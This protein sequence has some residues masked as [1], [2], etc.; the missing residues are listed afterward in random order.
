MRLAARGVTVWSPAG[1]PTARAEDLAVRLPDLAGGSRRVVDVRV[2]GLEADLERDARGRF[3]LLDLLPPETD[4]PSDQPLAIQI[5]G[6]RLR[7]FDRTAADVR[8]RIIAIP[9]LTFDGDGASWRASGRLRDVDGGATE[10]KARQDAKTQT[11]SLRAQ[12]AGL[13]LAPW[14]PIVRRTPAAKNFEILRE[15][16]AESFRARGQAE[17]T[18]EAQRPVALRGSLTA[19]AKGLRYAEF[20]ARSAHLIGQFDEASADGMLEAERPGLRARFSG[21]VNW[22]E[23]VRAFGRLEANAESSAA[24]PAALQKSLPKALAFRSAH[25]DGGMAF[26]PSTGFEVQ[27]AL[28]AQSATWDRQRFD[29]LSARVYAGPEWLSFRLAEGHSRGIRFGGAGDVALKARTLALAGHSDLIPIERFRAELGTD[30][31][32]GAAELTATVTG[33]IDRPE[34]ELRAKGVA[35]A[36]LQTGQ[37]IELGPFMGVAHLNGSRLE[38]KRLD[39][40]GPVG[41]ASVSG[42]YHFETQALDLGVVANGIDLASLRPDLAGTATGRFAVS[43]T[44]RDVRAVGPV[45]I[46]GLS[47]QEQTI[48]LVGAELEVGSKSLVA[49]SVTAHRGSARAQGS[50]RWTYDTGALDGSFSAQSLQLH[51][52]FAEGIEGGV[53]VHGGQIGGTLERPRLE[54]RFQGKGLL[55]QGVKV[56][57]V[58]GQGQIE[59]KRLAMVGGEAT[60]GR[61]RLQVSGEYDLDTRVGKAEGIAKGLPFEAV[62]ALLP[63]EVVLAGGVDFQFSAGLAEGQLAEAKIEGA[64]DRLGING[65]LFGSGEFL[66]SNQ[67][68]RWAGRVEIGQPER[69]IEIDSFQYDRDTDRL[70]AKLASY[71]LPLRDLF[72]AARPFATGGPDAPE[73]GDLLSPS[74]LAMLDRLDGDLDVGLALSGPIGSPNLAIDSILLRN[75]VVD[76]ESAGQIEANGSRTDKQW[77]IAGMKWTGGPGTL[78]LK[79]GFT[80][81]GPISIDGNLYNLDTKWLSR[82]LPA[83]QKVSGEATLFFSVSGQTQN[84]QIEASLS[85]SLFEAALAGGPRNRDQELKLDIYPILVADGAISVNGLFNFRGFS[86]DLKGSIPFRYPFEFPADQEVD[87]ALHVPKRPIETLKDLFTKLDVKRTKGAVWADVAV[88]GKPN[89]LHFDGTVNLEAES[90]GLSEFDTVLTNVQAQSRFQE[91]KV[92]LSATAKSS[93]GGDVSAQGAVQFQSFGELFGGNLDEMLANRIEGSLRFNRLKVEERDLPLDPKRTSLL[94]FSVGAVNGGVRVSGSLRDPLISTFVPLALENVRGEI[95]SLLIE[96]AEA[97]PPLVS[98]RFNIAYVVGTRQAPAEVRAAASVLNLYGGGTLKG[99][100]EDLE[101]QANLTLRSGYLRL[102]NARINLQD[103]GSVKLRYDSGAL[104]SDLRLDVDIEGRTALSAIRFGSL[105]E[106]YDIYLEM[107]GNLLNPE[108]QIISARSDPPDLSQERIMNLLGQIELVQ[109]LSSQLTGAQER[110]QLEQAL[111]TLA[112]PVLFDPVTESLARQLGLEYL[113]L[114]Y[115]PLGQ[116]SAIAAKWLGKGFTLQGRREI[117]EAA[118]GISDYDLRLTYRPPRRIRSLRGLTFSVGIDQERP[119]KIAVEYG[120]RFG[121][122]GGSANPRIIKIG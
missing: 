27:G 106:R 74:A 88:N 110:R 47:I 61:G 82:F 96:S 7:F 38:V 32:R 57:A 97:S 42:T 67:G 41:V 39:I 22:S 13:D 30:R 23:A 36:A 15:L 25:F 66:V 55:L 104:D 85:G 122:S 117:S 19:D 113:S 93:K 86:G 91:G 71:S 107:R 65:A 43:G 51:D 5:E 37:F 8:P 44:P 11:L 4:E 80:E 90:I 78:D 99:R 58:Q 3:T 16:D 14:L 56:D 83:L 119:W 53:E 46:Y 121:S 2:R 95:P 49:R 62:H 103:G 118:D 12:L 94:N 116:T 31:L 79:G 1:E 50:V 26:A 48:P 87:I 105:I 89:A 6:A 68:P 24:L 98:P 33:S 52:F 73:A 17:L 100:L 60:V 63:P 34:V 101:A 35:A 64:I 108:Q 102:P 72:R 92:Q 29:G 45:E 81:S 28:R 21:R 59:G 111:S 70:E 10:F 20:S 40:A 18:I 109:Q 9:R 69:Y 54:A 114:E 76:G 120:Q 77:K 75:L 84:P 112:I 115:G